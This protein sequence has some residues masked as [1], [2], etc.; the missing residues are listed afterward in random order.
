ME[1]LEAYEL[2]DSY[3]AAAELAGCDHH[4]VARYV[5]LR[6]VE[7]APKTRAHQVR[8]I[9]PFRPKIEE[10]MACSR[11]RIRADRAHQRLVA[12]G[13]G[14]GERTT[15]RAVAEA[16][17]GVPGRAAAGAPAM[18]PRAGAV[19]ALG[20]ATGPQV[21]AR[22][23]RLWCDWLAWSATPARGGCRRVA[24]PGRGPRRRLSTG[25]TNAPSPPVRATSSILHMGTIWEQPA[26]NLPGRARTGRHGHP[27]A[28]L[29]KRNQQG[30]Y[31]NDLKLGGTVP[32]RLENR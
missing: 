28:D 6:A 15:R 30:P 5:L 25:G 2:T 16:K 9:E 22:V 23:V 31:G 7:E 29:R 4:T 27:R 11:G 1:I 10:L 14:G 8:P 3:R 12:M 13:F 26:R 24:Q 17:G 19:A 18:D 32:N 21:A 20:P